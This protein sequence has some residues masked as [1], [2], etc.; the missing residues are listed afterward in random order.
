[1]YGQRVY[2]NILQFEFRNEQRKGVENLFAAWNGERWCIYRST[3]PLAKLISYVHIGWMA[4]SYIPAGRKC[5][6]LSD[7]CFRC[8]HVCT[9]ITRMKVS[10]HRRPRNERPC[11]LNANRVVMLIRGSP[12]IFIFTLLS[13]FHWSVTARHLCAEIFFN[14]HQPRYFSLAVSRNVALLFPSTLREEFV[15]N[16]N[17]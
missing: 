11:R 14:F 12:F 15:G 4:R 13:H 9:Y 16:S 1:M 17:N 2:T 7:L 6:F 10:E 3:V 8:T 5:A